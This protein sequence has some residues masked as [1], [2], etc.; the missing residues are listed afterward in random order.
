MRK[1][2]LYCITLLTLT[3]GVVARPRAV[4]AQACASYT[5]VDYLRGCTA[6]TIGSVIVSC[7][8]DWGRQYNVPC[9]T[10]TCQTY[11]NFCSSND[12]SQCTVANGCQLNAS[13]CTPA[14]CGVG[15][16]GGSCPGECRQGSSCGAGYS[17][18]SGC[19][20]SGPGGGC[21][22]NQVCCSAN[23]CGGGGGGS[24]QCVPP[25]DCPP[26]TF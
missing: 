4:F 12:F 6:N 9:G 24:V 19:S 2:F 7:E 14:T 5:T 25:A 15:G 3:V 18:A 26:G 10:S 17:G 22:S 21:K 16:G 13:M 8:P 1:I 23:S 11:G 20:G